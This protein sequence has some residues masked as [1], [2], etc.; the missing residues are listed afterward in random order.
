MWSVEF[1]KVLSKRVPKLLTSKTQSCKRNFEILI[2]PN[3]AK[4]GSNGCLSIDVRRYII[5]LISYPY[6]KDMAVLSKD[7][8][9]MTV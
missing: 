9:V 7:T 2:S 3:P 5:C 4:L 1:F 8:R 6:E